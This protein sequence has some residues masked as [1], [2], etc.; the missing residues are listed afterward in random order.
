MNCQEFIDALIK[1]GYTIE[2]LPSGKTRCSKGGDSFLYSP[3]DAVRY[4]VWFNEKTLNYER[5]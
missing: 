4:G 1:Q 5:I 2:D 3:L